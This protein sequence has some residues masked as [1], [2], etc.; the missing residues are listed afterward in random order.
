MSKAIK[1]TFPEYTLLFRTTLTIALAGLMLAGCSTKTPPSS[2]PSSA[3]VRADDHAAKKVSAD[4]PVSVQSV[5]ALTQ[6]LRR[7]DGNIIEIDFRG[8]DDRRL[9]IKNR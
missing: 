8:V 1:A 2:E 7:E 6:K 4:D 3:E 5:E 9:G